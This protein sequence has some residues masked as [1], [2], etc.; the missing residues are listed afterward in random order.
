[1][2]YIPAIPASF[3]KALRRAG[4]AALVLAIT[5]F[6]LEAS[7]RALFCWQGSCALPG[8]AFY[9]KARHDILPDPFF[10]S[11]PPVPDP[12]FG[13]VY[14]QPGTN[15]VGLSSPVNYPYR[16]RSDEYVIGLFGGSL[17][18]HVFY[19]IQS[20][21]IEKELK[22]VPWLQGR[23]IVWLNFSQGC[24]RQPQQFIISSF[25]NETLDLSVNL[26]GYNEIAMHRPGS[27]P[28]EPCF[29]HEIFT[30]PSGTQESKAAADGLRWWQAFAANAMASRPALARSAALHL[31]WKALHNGLERRI[32][33]IRRAS[34]E[35]DPG[36]AW[37]PVAEGEALVSHWEKFTTLQSGIASGENL[38]SLFFL[39][40]NQHVKGSKPLAA[41][42]LALWA[43]IPG[44]REKQERI[45]Q[46]Y[47][48]L[49]KSA[50][51][52]RAQG[53][54]VIDL[55]GIFAQHKEPLYADDCC[56]LN[57]QGRILLAKRMV[58][59]I[60]GRMLSQKIRGP[61]P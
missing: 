53:V 10:Q 33:G 21:E 40:P 35:P 27:P 6:L 28:T 25:Y 19:S 44:I 57:D 24:M 60:V 36:A 20:P 42:E 34:R 32:Q 31:A 18:L 41:E 51:R 59:E 26:D 58:G 38:P 1:M 4:E 2:T 22:K 39:Q 23:K 45:Q 3:K 5:A 61:R 11:S 15:N 47:Q 43:N 17:A 54:Q 52:L 56:H 48:G 49:R 13:Y 8:Q 30:D 7:A 14:R 9:L 46:R 29:Y 50:E 37:D 12:F 55:T 16:K